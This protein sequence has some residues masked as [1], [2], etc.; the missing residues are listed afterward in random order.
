M[1]TPDTLSYMIAGYV[2]IFGGIFI[3]ITSLIWRTCNL[4][5]EELLL[6]ET[7]EK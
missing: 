4:R 2:I 3:Y 1:D 7:R 6:D 5:Q